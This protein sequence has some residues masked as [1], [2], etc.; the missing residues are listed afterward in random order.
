MYKTLMNSENTL[1]EIK[2]DN[3]FSSQVKNDINY[4]ENSLDPNVLH[5]VDDSI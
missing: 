5:I 1:D 3:Y 4:K 2:I